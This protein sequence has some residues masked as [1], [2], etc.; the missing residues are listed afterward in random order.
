MLEL[1]D[2]EDADDGEELEDELEELTP[3]WPPVVASAPS[4]LKWPSITTTFFPAVP[5]I[6]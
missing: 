1:D 6:A 5:Q 3:P 4:P 2:S